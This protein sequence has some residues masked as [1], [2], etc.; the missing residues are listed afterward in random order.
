MVFF[1]RWHPPI[2]PATPKPQSSPD[3]SVACC[4]LEKPVKSSIRFT[5]K[6]CLVTMDL[7]SLR[8]TIHRRI[9][10]G[11]LLL[12]LTNLSARNTLLV[13]LRTW[14]AQVFMSE[15]VA[16]WSWRTVKRLYRAVKATLVWTLLVLIWWWVRPPSWVQWNRPTKEGPSQRVALRASQT[17]KKSEAN[18]SPGCCRDSELG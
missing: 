10:C 1:Q 18:E 3:S 17:I 8:P 12:T 16:R 7:T 13:L 15:I 14:L 4:L 11:P 5:E 9:V 2:L 6:K